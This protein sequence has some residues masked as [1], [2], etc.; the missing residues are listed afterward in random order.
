MQTT[1]AAVPSWNFVL[2]LHRVLRFFNS[3]TSLPES[4]GMKAV[5]MERGGQ[6]VA[7]TVYEGFNGNN[8]WMHLAAEPGARWMTRGFLRYCFHYPFNE[9]GVSRV[10]GY[11]DASNDKAIKLNE[12]LGFK[13]EALLKGAAP[14]GDDV[15]IYVMNK[16]DCRWI[17][18]EQP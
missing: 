7:G 13:R 1:S 11:V 9:V 16:T 18:R 6:V 17:G 2:D 14:D 15:I 4:V 10:S 12:H 5:G 8:V 3:R